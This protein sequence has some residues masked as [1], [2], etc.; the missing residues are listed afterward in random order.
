MMLR[1]GKVFYKGKFE[2]LD[3]QIQNNHIIE[4]SEGNFS[5]WNHCRIYC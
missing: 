1:N 3:I 5:K 4:A 2:D